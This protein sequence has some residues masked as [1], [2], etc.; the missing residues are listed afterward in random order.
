[1]TTANLKLNLKTDP[2][3]TLKAMTF[4]TVQL[5][6]HFGKVFTPETIRLYAD[7]LEGYTVASL[8][9]AV[10]S[11]I[12]SVSHLPPN[13]LPMIIRECNRASGICGAEGVSLFSDL[14]KAIPNADYIA[15]GSVR[16]ALYVN[17][18]YGAHLDVMIRRM[19]SEIAWRKECEAVFTEYESYSLKV[20]REFSSDLNNLALRGLRHSSGIPAVRVIGQEKRA[21]LAAKLIESSLVKRAIDL[22]GLHT[23]PAV[24]LPDHS[25]S[26]GEVKVVDKHEIAATVKAL[27]SLCTEHKRKTPGNSE[28]LE[29]N[30]TL[31]EVNNLQ[32]T[33][34]MPGTGVFSSFTV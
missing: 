33:P 23:P 30:N 8:G 32:E 18:T 15:C 21:R 22:Q 3:R 1:M 25:G 11:L 17:R 16:L 10:R 34:A 12:S 19:G 24:Q 6:E 28:G 14:I 9:V 31:N 4:A 2:E 13:P 26:A 29:T 20:L 5:N 27:L 7:L